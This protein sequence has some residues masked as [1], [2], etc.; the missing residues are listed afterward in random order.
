MEKKILLNKID[1]CT[2]IKYTANDRMEVRD[3]YSKIYTPSI[4][5]R[6]NQDHGGLHSGM[7]Y[8]LISST[9]SGKT[10]INR[11]LIMSCAKEIKILLYSS[12]EDEGAVR[13]GLDKA[14]ANSEAVKNIRLIEEKK[15]LHYVDK[16]NT[17]MF[18]KILRNKIIESGVEVLFFDNLTTSAFYGESVA[19]QS[20]FALSLYPLASELN[21]AVFLVAHTST[22]F[23][24]DNEIDDKSIRGSKMISQKVEYMYGFQ[25][26]LLDTMSEQD[27]FS[28]VRVIKSRF[29]SNQGN[30]Y[31]LMWDPG[32]GTYLRDYKLSPKA[33]KELW[34]NR[35][36]FKK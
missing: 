18:L 28:F 4:P 25:R 13:W 5:F 22:D 3:K 1:V 14:S 30:H 11:Q 27:Y 24:S 34:A 6:F 7:V 2:D 8:L 10:S 21:C 9:G 12:E 17:E 23:T 15:L 19:D 35:M 32:E 33:F 16:G 29:G 31:R 20:S 26:T 36:R